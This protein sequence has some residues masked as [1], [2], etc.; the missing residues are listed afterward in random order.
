MNENQLKTA[1]FM[2]GVFALGGVALILYQHSLHTGQ[3]M[4][5]LGGGAQTPSQPAS[6]AG[7]PAKG[8]SNL[9]PFPASVTP[10]GSGA[11]W[12][13]SGGTP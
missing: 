2:A 13:I 6:L 11:G 3:I 10:M 1:F 5:A 12:S 7:T 9:I 4:Q 8:Q